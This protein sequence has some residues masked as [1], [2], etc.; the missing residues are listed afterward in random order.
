MWG[1]TMSETFQLAS[2]GPI[3]DVSPGYFL[4]FKI[5]EQWF[6]HELVKGVRL[7][8]DMM[9]EFAADYTVYSE[10]FTLPFDTTEN[11]EEY[12]RRYD[13]ALKILR[14]RAWYMWA[15]DCVALNWISILRWFRVTLPRRLHE[16]I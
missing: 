13:K 15:G 6:E 1:E 12:F 8:L 2:F 7:S 4:N 16:R 10:F 5:R 14:T 9:P 11:I 3:L